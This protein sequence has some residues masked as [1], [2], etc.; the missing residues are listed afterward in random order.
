MKVGLFGEVTPS[1]LMKWNRWNN[2]DCSFNISIID[3]FLLDLNPQNKT[4]SK[5]INDL[6]FWLFANFA[7]NPN[8]DAGF[9]K[10]LKSMLIS[11]ILRN[12]NENACLTLIKF[13]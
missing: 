7:K 11:D 13:E 4:I 5:H 1:D 10:C 2:K 9:R 6:G 8:I 3:R 12:R